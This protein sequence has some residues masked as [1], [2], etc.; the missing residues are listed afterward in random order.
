MMENTGF[1]FNQEF[2]A[3]PETAET[4]ELNDEVMEDNNGNERTQYELKDGSMGSRAAYIRELF[5]EDNL[6]RKE[7]ADRTGFPYRAVYSATVNMVNDAEPAGRGRAASNPTILVAKDNTDVLVH[8]LEDGRYVIAETQE[9]IAED[10]VEEVLRNEWIKEQVGAGVSRGDVAKALD[11]SYGV[12][13]NLT[14][15]LAGTRTQHNITLDDGTV[16]SRAEYIRQQYADGISRSD[17]AKELGV[18][19]SVVWQA[20]KVEKTAADKFEEAIEQ[21]KGF[22][23]KVVDVDAFNTIIEALELVEI[24]DEEEEEE[25]EA[26]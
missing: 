17:I 21:I 8:K 1:D 4:H 2:E 6:S 13:Y 16:I 20:T 3:T 18:A 22:A 9:E 12:I 5:L 10:Q 25:G 24:A 15:E 14:K 11:L 7:I 19:Y 23:D 26:N